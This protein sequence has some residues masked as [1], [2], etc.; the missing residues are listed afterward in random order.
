MVTEARRKSSQCLDAAL[1]ALA[2]LA[3]MTGMR[4]NAAER[5]ARAP[6]KVASPPPPQHLL[7]M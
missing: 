2:Q 5:G 6:G 3:A 1:L 4:L 7:L